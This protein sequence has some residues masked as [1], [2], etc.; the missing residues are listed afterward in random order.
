[1]FMVFS[2]SLELE[3]SDLATISKDTVKRIGFPLDYT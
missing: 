3:Q 2:R 1:M